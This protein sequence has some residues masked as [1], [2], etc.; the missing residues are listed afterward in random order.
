M[1]LGMVLL[2]LL[3]LLIVG[4]TL[5]DNVKDLTA[6]TRHWM[7]GGPPEPPAWLHK[8]PV[9]GAKAVEYWQT[10][11]TDN[12]KLWADLRRLIEPLSAALLKLGLLVVGGLVQLALSVLIAFFLFRDGVSLAERLTTA[13]DR[14]GGERGKQLLSVAGNTIRGV[15]YGILGTAL[16]QGIMAG[17]GYVIA[18]VPGAGVLAM[19]TFF[20]S[21]LPLLGTAIVWVPAAIWLFYQGSTGWGVF[22]LIWGFGVNSIEHVVKPFL[23]SKGS[24]LPFLLIF[25]GVLG[26]AFAF[27]FIGVFLGPTLLALGY[28]LVQEW[29][30]A[31]ALAAQAAGAKP[32]AAIETASKPGGKP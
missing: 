4:S 9:V 6:A 17:V 13:V 18:G 31:N 28:G 7:E 12:A 19:L 21:V 16:V 2:L 14:I 24:D 20:V 25:F 8:V 11:A 29:G 10:L 30:A 32:V 15:V 26:G 3:P 5:A 1:G 22:M 23:I 27:G